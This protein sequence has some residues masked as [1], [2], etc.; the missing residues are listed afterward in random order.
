TRAEWVVL[1]AQD[2]E[3]RPVSI[4]ARGLTARVFQHEL[5]HL[6]GVLFIDHLSPLRKRLLNGKLR[7]IAQGRTDAKYKMRFHPVK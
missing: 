3:G 6:D 5:D 4:R 1:E 7:D 2:L